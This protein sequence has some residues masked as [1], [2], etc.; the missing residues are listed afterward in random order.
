MKKILSVLILILMLGAC[1]KNDPILEE[2]MDNGVV[3]IY[4]SANQEFYTGHVERTNKNKNGV[5]YVSEKGDVKNGVKNGEYIVY[6]DNGKINTKVNYNNGVLNGLSTTFNVFGD[7]LTE[8]M[9]VNGELEGPFIEVRKLDNKKFV[10]TIKNGHYIGLYEEYYDYIDY[11]GLHKTVT[12]NENGKMEG[13]YIEYNTEGK[14][15][16]RTE[17]K[18][19]IIHGFRE[20]YLYSDSN[21]KK[22]IDFKGYYYKGKKE[23]TIIRN[24]Y[25]EK[26]PIISLDDY[27]KSIENYFT[28]EK[29]DNKKSEFTIEYYPSGNIK[30]YEHS[31]GY[32]AGTYLENYSILSLLE[33]IKERRIMVNKAKT[34]D[35]LSSEYKFIQDI[36]ADILGWNLSENLTDLQKKDLNTV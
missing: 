26:F 8:V 22:I 35:D 28:L 6:W 21:N 17:Y 15:W 5:T 10:G 33:V 20:M 32:L 30:S 31:D 16:E 13:T 7:L 12:F 19:G 27:K 11:K 4:D 24:G 14:V 18:N 34:E 36:Y 29:F 2:R 1:G 25:S 3:K 9:Y 23:G